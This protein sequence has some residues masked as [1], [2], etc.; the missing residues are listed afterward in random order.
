MQESVV[1]SSK[2]LQRLSRWK[3]QQTD[4][5]AALLYNIRCIYKGARGRC[6]IEADAKNSRRVIADVSTS[7]RA[8]QTN[9]Q[10]LFIENKE[11]S[12]TRRLHALRI[13]WTSPT[14]RK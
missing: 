9:N 1:K 3:Y 5:K 6:V 2:R 13:T 11:N 7:A 12:T 4:Q 14:L 10:T 8:S